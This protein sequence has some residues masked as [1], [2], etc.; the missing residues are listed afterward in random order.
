MASSLKSKPHNPTRP[1]QALTEQQFEL[2]ER[3]KA[4]SVA[5]YLSHALHCYSPTDVLTGDYLIKDWKPDLIT[6][7]LEDLHPRNLRQVTSIYTMFHQSEFMS[8]V[9]VLSKNAKYLETKVEAHYGT[10]YHV[11]RISEDLLTQWQVP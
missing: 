1:L 8:R 5:E 2:K 4:V 10:E 11:D 6:R 3:E 9:T 7:M